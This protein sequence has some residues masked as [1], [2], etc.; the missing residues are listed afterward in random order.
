M[1]AIRSYYAGDPK[2]V[3]FLEF[4]HVGF[5][6]QGAE[7]NALSDISFTANSGD[8]IGIIGSTGSGKTTLINLIPRFYEVSE[9]SI[10]IEG[11]DSSVMQ[12]V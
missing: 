11:K 1:Y 2:S 8:T 5:R 7:T 6:Y 12:I 4:E 10:R 9:G 3:P